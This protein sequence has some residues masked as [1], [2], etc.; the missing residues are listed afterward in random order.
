MTLAL[1]LTAHLW[2]LAGFVTGRWL[3]AR[4]GYAWRAEHTLLCLLLWPFLLAWL[5]IRRVRGNL[6][7][8][9]R[10]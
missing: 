4:A 10:E 7:H 9:L 2:L 3:A 8:D 5:G 6:H 1:P